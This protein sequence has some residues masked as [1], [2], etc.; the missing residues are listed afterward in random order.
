MIGYIAPAGPWCNRQPLM[1][2][3]TGTG[4]TLSVTGDQFFRIYP[5][6]TAGNF[7]LEMISSAGDKSSLVE[8]FNMKGEK[9]WTEVLIG[10]QKHEFSLKGK[11]AGIYLVRIINENYSGTMRIVK[12]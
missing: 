7:T 3:A 9:I 6:P 12:Q 5:N 11:P 10:F 2:V 8:I 1:A 4:E